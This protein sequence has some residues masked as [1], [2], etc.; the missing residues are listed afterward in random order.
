MEKSSEIN[1]IDLHR[2]YL[3]F[4][5]NLIL[6]VSITLAC[7]VIGFIV[8]SYIIKP[9]YSAST[10]MYVNNSKTEN[11]NN[12]ITQ[13]DL[14]AATNLVDTYSVVLKS[15]SFLQ[16]VIDSLNLDIDYE[17][18][19][20]SI[21]ISSVNKTQ[22]M[23]IVVNNGSS[24]AALKIVAKI[25]ELAPAAIMNSM[26]SG[27]VKVVDQPWTSGKPVSPSIIK[28]TLIMALMGFLVTFLI[29]ILCDVFNNKF[30][31]SEDIHNILGLQ[32]IGIIPLES[33]TT[34]DAKK[35]KGENK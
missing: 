12:T 29:V 2:V 31:S 14:T 11:T 27:S 9:T 13:S 35:L 25:A 33:E 26:D 23:Q 10:T 7:G 19:S 22:V 18:L 17:V 20:K 32:V 16:Q 5:H 34:F 4:I 3:S 15:H 6:L 30:K 24:D 1:T 28:Y 21:T 8:S